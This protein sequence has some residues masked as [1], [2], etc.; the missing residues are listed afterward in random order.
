MCALLMIN[1]VIIKMIKPTNVDLIILPIIGS[2]DKS[3]NTG[4]KIIK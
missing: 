1:L 3:S 2:R 4:H